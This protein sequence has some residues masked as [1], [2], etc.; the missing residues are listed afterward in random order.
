VSDL[1]RRRIYLVLAAF[2]V[3]MGAIG[4]QLVSYQ[5]LRG[6]AL[7]QSARLERS[8]DRPV[9]A[10]RG[11]IADSAGLILA[12]TIPADRVDADLTR[13]TDDEELAR[14]LAGPLELAPREILAILRAGRAA[15][16]DSVQLRQRLMPERAAR[17]RALSLPCKPGE[18][19]CV[20]LTPEPARV[21]PNGE[22]AA[23][24]VGY[25][26]WDLEG[27]Y[28][29]ERSYNEEIGGRPGR[30]RVEAD[31]Q[32]NPIAVAPN[33]F[34]PPTDGLD[35]TLTIDGAVQRVV[36][37]QLTRAVES[38]GAAGGTAIVMDVRTGAILALASRPAF[39][40]N[41]FERFDVASHTNPAVTGLYEPGS[42]FKVLTM[43][44]G[45]ETGAVDANTIFYD[46]PGYIKVENKIIRNANDAVWGQETMSE[47]LQHSSN[48]GA[49]FVANRVGRDAFY[50][51]LRE[52]NIGQGT[53]IDLPG[54]EQGLVHRPDAPDWRP[55]TLTTN[56]FGQGISVTPIQLLAAVA[57]TVNGG[58]LMRPYVVKELRRDG[59]VVRT[60]E[61]QVVRRVVSPRVS[62]QIVEMMTAV[63]DNVS[64]R[65]VGVPG[66]AVGAKSGTAQIPAEGG[67]YEPGDVTIGSMIGV[68]PADNPR[69]AVLVKIDRPQKDPWGAH[70]AGPPTAQ[71][72]QDLFT[73]Y[74]IPPTR[75]G[76]TP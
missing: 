50:A 8:R 73:L 71:I 54:E 48:L 53:G 11:T 32:G 3:F 33:Q 17:L 4:A 56:A 41:R 76:G 52:F 40:P 62:R 36:E 65:F 42:T 9:P 35:V 63:V 72:L 10:R 6:A 49:A 39:D 5:V 26:N 60:V 67:G 44:I 18:L 74:G 29:V 34:E 68:G 57:A 38:Q 7:G 24:V 21:Y 75:R 45:L 37:Q 58:Q 13:I 59:A 15:G 43:A 46:R 12:T 30:A 27:M 23:H 2:V 1:P 64:A 66:Y 20:V 28:G 51:K 25:A 55:I 69:F 47:I 22:F 19:P 14:L 61:P 70:I 31:V 16:Q